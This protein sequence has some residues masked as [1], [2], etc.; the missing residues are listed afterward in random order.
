MSYILNIDTSESI[1]SICLADDETIYPPAFNN[2]RN[3]HAAW[4]HT[5]INTLLQQHELSPANLHAVAV[6]IGPGSYTGLRVSLSAAKGLCYA[7]DI[8]L[9][10]VNTLS[11]VALAAFAEAK[12]LICPMIDA[13]RMEV[14]TA[15]YDRQLVEKEKAKALIVDADSFSSLLDSYSILFCGSGSPKL[16][17]ILSHSNAAFS[18]VRAN[19]AHLAKLSYPL[20]LNKQFADTAYTEP[21]YIKD[22]FSGTGKK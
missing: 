14:F 12:D 18:T 4:L 1:A 19:A 11:M 9:I 16:Q 3:D 21:L 5:A 10:A 22:F 7:L 2:S 15:I 20:F 8:P 17:T 6:S 13:R